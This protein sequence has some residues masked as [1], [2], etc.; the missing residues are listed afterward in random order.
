ME[1][2]F[3]KLT[4][5]QLKAEQKDNDVEKRQRKKKKLQCQARIVNI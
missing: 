1:K 3:I 4:R 5:R 2:N